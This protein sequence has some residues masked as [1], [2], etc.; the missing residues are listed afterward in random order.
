MFLHAKKE[1]KMKPYQELEIN[2][3]SFVLQDIVTF[4][5]GTES[6]DDLGSWN[7]EWFP[8]NNKDGQ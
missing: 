3:I 6:V 5:V 8:A 1:G 7:Q 4:S 2:V